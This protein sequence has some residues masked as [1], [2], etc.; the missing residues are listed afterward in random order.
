MVLFFKVMSNERYI[1]ADGVLS[2]E[3]LITIGNAS[4]FN[5]M[6]QLLSFLN[7]KEPDWTCTMEMTRI[8]FC[9][10]LFARHNFYS[11]RIPTADNALS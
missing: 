11:T 4:R 9:K 6:S 5:R 10:S 3:V 8:I 2:R 1:I 7:R